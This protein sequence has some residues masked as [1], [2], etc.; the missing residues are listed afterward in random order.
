LENALAALR[1]YAA[2][3][4]VLV[5]GC[6]GD[7]DRAKRPLMGAIASR[8]ADVVYVTD[9]NP[10]SE[11][12]AQIRA[13][14]L[15]AAPHAIEIGHRADAIR[16][17]VAD[18]SAGDVMVVAGK[19]HEEGQKIGKQTLPFSDHAAVL[20]AIEGRDGHG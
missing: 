13:A 17:A 1:P 6:G 3:R 18:L 2:G 14:I 12:P 4:L 19:G 16:A 9:D 11:D 10:R 20:A 7:R 15:A 8:L 5:F